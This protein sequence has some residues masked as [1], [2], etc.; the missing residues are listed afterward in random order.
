VLPRGRHRLAVLLVLWGMLVVVIARMFPHDCS[1]ACSSFSLSLSLALTHSLTRVEYTYPDGRIIQTLLPSL[2]W[3]N[4]L[5]KF[6]LQL[7]A[8]RGENWWP[9]KAE[10]TSTLNNKKEQ[11]PPKLHKVVPDSVDYHAKRGA[12]IYTG[13]LRRN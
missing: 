13:K 2:C 7:S 6:G 3:R 10:P 4:H 12:F 8:E 11:T 1:L 5:G 9:T